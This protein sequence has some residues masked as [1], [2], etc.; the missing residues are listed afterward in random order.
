MPGRAR[1]DQWPRWRPCRR[2]Y[3]WQYRSESPALI[4]LFLPAKTLELNE[5]AS[6]V[7]EN[8]DGNRPVLRIIEMLAEKHPSVSRARLGRD[9]LRLLLSLEAEKLVYLL[10]EPL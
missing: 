8:V 10:W 1:L 3:L 6:L 7:W 2:Y 5:T 9:V 4:T